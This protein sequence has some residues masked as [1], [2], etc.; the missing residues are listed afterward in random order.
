M[1][2]I[3][4]NAISLYSNAI[5]MYRIECDSRLFFY[6]FQKGML[7]LHN[8]TPIGVHGNLKSTNCVIDSRWVCKITDIG[9]FKFKEGQEVDIEVGEEQKYNSM[10]SP[11]IVMLHPYIAM[12]HPYIVMS[13][14]YKVMSY[15]YGNV[16]SLYSNVASLFCILT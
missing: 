9:L 14:F 16:T 13:Y 3:Y 4:S 2:S 5:S 12:L 15:L 6:C 8:N 7:Y 11:C 1:L 10:L